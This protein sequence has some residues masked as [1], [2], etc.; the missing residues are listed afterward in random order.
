[1]QIDTDEGEVNVPKKLQTFWV[2]SRSYEKA[3]E[4]KAGGQQKLGAT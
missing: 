4:M 1:M 3:D 2:C